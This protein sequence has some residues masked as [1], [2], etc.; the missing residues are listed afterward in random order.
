MSRMVLIVILV[1]FA[2]G[3]DSGRND[4]SRRGSRSESPENARM[5]RF[6]DAA[7]A[8]PAAIDPCHGCA[9]VPRSTVLRLRGLRDTSLRAGLRA[10]TWGT[11]TPVS[12]HAVSALPDDRV[13]HESVHRETFPPS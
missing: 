4:S 10:A 3:E 1:A 2:A 12:G 9:S 8:R 13:R 5:I 7:S 11:E 6:Q